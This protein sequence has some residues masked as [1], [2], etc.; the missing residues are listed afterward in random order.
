[1]DGIIDGFNDAYSSNLIKSSNYINVERFSNTSMIEMKDIIKKY[2]Q[3][4]CL[5]I[6][7][8]IFI[9]DRK[10]FYVVRRWCELKSTFD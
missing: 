5:N 2:E 3:I 4:G 6:E 1:M 8:L 10:N 7:E 9:I